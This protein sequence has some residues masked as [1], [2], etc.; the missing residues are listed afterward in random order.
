MNSHFG[1]WPVGPLGKFGSF[2]KTLSS[3]EDC[4]DWFSDDEC[5]SG[6]VCGPTDKSGEYRC[7]PLSKEKKKG[8]QYG[9]QVLE[10]FGKGFDLYSSLQERMGLQ[11]KADAVIAKYEAQGQMSAN[12]AQAAKDQV[13]LQLGLAASKERQK[14]NLQNTILGLAV[15]SLA[16]GGGLVALSMLKK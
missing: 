14:K 15:V 3:G 8:A 7:Q 2:G 12:E 5:G 10:L 13:S 1:L 6:L 16:V 9:T 11:A 4:G